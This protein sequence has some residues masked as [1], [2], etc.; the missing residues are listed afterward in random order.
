MYT[1]NSHPN[2]AEF[3]LSPFAALRAARSGKAN[4][5]NVTCNLRK[6]SFF[7]RRWVV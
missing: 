7:A 4:G 6:D 1:S 3:T 5:L 2:L